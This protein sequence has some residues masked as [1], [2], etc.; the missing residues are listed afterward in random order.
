MNEQINND[1]AGR[2]KP[3]ETQSVFER[4]YAEEPFTDRFLS[5]RDRAVDVIIPVMHTNELWRR[6]LVCCYRE[7]PVN[8]LILADGGC[9][10]DTIRIAEQFPRVVVLDH[11]N[12][13]SL[14]FSIRKLIEEVRTDWFVYL[15]SDVFLPPGWFDHMSNYRSRYD[16]YECRQQLVYLIEYPLDYGNIRRPLS[17][18]QMGRRDAF[19]DVLPLIDDDYLYRTEDIIIGELVQKAGFRYGRVDD[20]FH[21]HQIMQKPSQWLRRVTEVSY[22]VEPSRK[23]EIRAWDM[24]ARAIVKYMSPDP[25]RISWVRTSID[26]LKNLKA[27]DVVEF[28]QWVSNTNPAWLEYIDCA[29]QVRRPFAERWRDFTKAAR[30]LVFG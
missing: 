29:P 26:C 3:A 1:A 5:E 7:I 4:L 15:H 20:L 10:D 14:G 27:I 9:I 12:V 13:R 28:R 2:V 25:D 11:R 24:H 21:Y 18:S 8:R 30:G 6:N 22:K 23:E 16:W 19:K 17:G